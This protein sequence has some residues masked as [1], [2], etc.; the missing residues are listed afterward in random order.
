MVLF[1]SFH[2]SFPHE[3]DEAYTRLLARHVRTRFKWRRGPRTNNKGAGTRTRT[4]TATRAKPP[5]VRTRA[6]LV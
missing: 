4:S 2:T 5:V 6:G 1:L 3:S